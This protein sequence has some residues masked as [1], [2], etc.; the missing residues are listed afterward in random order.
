MSHSCSNNIHWMT[1]WI[2]VNNSDKQELN[3]WKISR[4]NACSQTP[5]CIYF[6]PLGINLSKIK[7]E[8]WFLIMSVLLLYGLFLYIFFS[9]AFSALL[10]SFSILELRT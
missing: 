9:G 3:K 2:S 10:I 8:F 5:R 1:Q 4:G 7:I 6:S